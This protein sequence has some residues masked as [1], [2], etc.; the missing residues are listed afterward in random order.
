[1]T[2]RYTAGLARIRG[3]TITSFKRLSG[4]GIQAGDHLGLNL[5]S[6]TLFPR[7]PVEQLGLPKG[8]LRLEP[9]WFKQKGLSRLGV[10]YKAGGCTKKGSVQGEGI[11]NI[12]LSQA[13]SPPTAS[14]TCSLHDTASS[15]LDHDSYIAIVVQQRMADIVLTY[16]VF[17]IS[18]WFKW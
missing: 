15:G 4:L 6:L 14:S 11:Y 18:A 17:L 1:M 16:I 9:G 12:Y 5:A 3:R 2:G 13:P 10:P 7:V 8:D